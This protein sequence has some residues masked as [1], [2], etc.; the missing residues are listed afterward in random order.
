MSISIAGCSSLFY[1]PSHDVYFDVEKLPA[2]TESVRF[3]GVNKVNLSGLYLRPK[4]MSLKALHQRPIIVQFHGNAQNLTSHFASLFWLIDEGYDY[5]IFDYEGYG[6]SEGHPTM[7]GTVDDGFAALDYIESRFPHRPIVLVGQSL[8]GAIA[9]RVAIEAKNKNY[10]IRLAVIESSFD[11]YQA[12]ARD[13]MSRSWVTW[14]F[15]PLT[16]LF[17]SDSVAPGDQI[18]AISPTPMVIV[19][20]KSD[21]VIPYK[22][23]ERIFAKAKDPKEFWSY[24]SPG[25]VV[26]YSADK[27]V[28]R[29]RL[30]AKLKTIDEKW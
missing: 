17:V 14:L 19:H 6:Q 9:M 20:G 16:Y 3:A 18:A 13:M 7:R 24:E 5:F 25:H 8:G 22:F 28:L 23:G 2:Q 11:S 1:Y 12:I 30:L 4:K 21:P 26:A 10:P 27:G 15:Q 29:E